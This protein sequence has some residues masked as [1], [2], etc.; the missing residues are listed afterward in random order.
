MAEATVM[1]YENNHDCSGTKFKGT[2]AATVM[3]CFDENIE[4][5]AKFPLE[6]SEIDVMVPI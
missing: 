2:A 3:C 1:Q 4:R 5:N 6:A